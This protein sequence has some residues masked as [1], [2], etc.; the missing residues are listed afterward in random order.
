LFRRTVAALALAAAIAGLRAGAIE[1]HAGLRSSEPR[2]GVRLGDTP[3]VIRLAF[4]ERPEVSLSSIRVLDTGGTAHHVDRPDA[5]PGDPLSLAIRVRPLPDGI[6]IVH[7]RIVSAVDG[8]AT[9]GSYAFGVRVSPGGASTAAT[10]TYPA[11]SPLEMVARWILLI[12]LT[13]LLGA[14]TARLGNFGGTRE[15]GV[16]TLGVALS[17]LGL[18]LLAEAQARNAGTALIDLLSTTIGRALLWRGAGI[19]AATVAVAV[20]FWARRAVRPRVQGAAMAAVAIGALASMAFHVQAGHAAAVPRFPVASIASQ[21]L[22]FAAAAIWI[23][24]LA[25]LIVGVR[26]E[27]GKAKADAALRFSTIAGVALALVAG[28]GILRGIQELSSWAQLI[29]TAYGQA[30]LAK[31]VLLIVIGALG[32]VHRWRTLPA[33]PVTLRPLRRLAAVELVLMIVVLAAAAVLGVLPPPSAGRL[34]QVSTIDASGADFATTIRARLTTGSDQPGP[35]RF[36]VRLEDYD[37]RQPIA[38]ARVSLRFTP[39]DDPG[40]ASSSLPLDATTDGAYEGSGAHLAFDGRWNVA[41]LV[42]RG[43]TSTEVPLDV[44]TR[45]DREPAAV[46]RLPGQPARYVV[47]VKGEGYVWISPDPERPGA[48]QL[49]ITIIDLINEYRAIDQ[50]VVTAAGP[51]GVARHQAVRAIDRSNFI[52]DVQLEAGRNTIAV[53]ARAANGS[54]LRAVADIDLPAH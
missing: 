6:Y 27:P 53:V 44:E 2:D 37:S 29:S 16:A 41:V 14:A 36:T 54:R 7:W 45:V 24:G 1:A 3:K 33:A 9:A 22:H 20:A 30:V 52:A 26:G 47:M 15:L 17:L 10:N 39:L 13:A 49:R 11:A 28:T 21:W 4:F 38:G 18:A 43:G 51:G 32:A 12:G 34:F 42:Q 50:I 48:S 5:V 35:N 40:T 19:G 31:A 46:T 25:A 23:G 8:H